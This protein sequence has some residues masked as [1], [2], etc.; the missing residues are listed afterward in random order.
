MECSI[1]ITTIPT[2]FTW[3]NFSRSGPPCS[4]HIGLAEERNNNWDKEKI[5]A[6]LRNRNEVP[7]RENKI[8]RTSVPSN[9]RSADRA[10]IIIDA[11]NNSV[12]RTIAGI[13]GVTASNQTRFVRMMKFFRHTRPRP[14][15]P[16][17]GASL[18]SRL[19]CTITPTFVSS[20]R[21]CLTLI[22]AHFRR[23]RRPSG[24][25][26]QLKFR[27]SSRPART[28]GRARRCWPFDPTAPG[29][30]EYHRLYIPVQTR[31]KI[32]A[33]VTNIAAATTAAGRAR[34]PRQLSRLE[35][36]ESARRTYRDGKVALRESRLRQRP[37]PMPN[38]SMCFSV[39]NISEGEREAGA[40]ARRLTTKEPQGLFHHRIGEF[41][42]SLDC[43]TW[44]GDR[45]LRKKYMQRGKWREIRRVYQVAPMTFL[46]YTC[47]FR[48]LLLVC[49]SFEVKKILKRL[50]MANRN[51]IIFV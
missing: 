14:T 42:F 50:K 16:R 46:S 44:C 4:H 24:L 6:L 27:F 40:P 34:S 21:R 38:K 43:W 20:R 47:F 48:W 33:S 35:A 9:D 32:P 10:T 39:L 12:L 3:K 51:T 7:T 11:T 19:S 13:I 17:S 15:I 30:P 1:I 5:M 26:R 29:S 2:R 22:H 31:P 41:A 25:G 37:L 49:F 36:R 23:F 28:G 8:A 18:P 45:L